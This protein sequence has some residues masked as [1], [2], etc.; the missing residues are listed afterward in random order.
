MDLQFIL[1][2]TINRRLASAHVYA[3]D[4]SKIEGPL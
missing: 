4:V 3:I 2:M 1:L